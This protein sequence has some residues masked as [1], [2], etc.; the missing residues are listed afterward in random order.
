[1]AT[2]RAKTDPRILAAA[3]AGGVAAGAAVAEAAAAAAEQL[4]RRRER[5]LR[6]R[7]RY[8]LGAGEPLAA[9]VRRIA[10]G[11]LDLIAD[12][13]ASISNDAS[14]DPVHEARKA[15]KRLRA[16]VRLTRDQLGDD[17]RA[18]ENAAFRDAGRVL[19]SQRDAEVM[20]EALDDLTRRAGNGVQPDALAGLRATLVTARERE[21]EAD[22]GGSARARVLTAVAAARERVAEW[23]LP[24]DAGVDALAPG[25]RRI[26][27]QGRRAYRAA[28][29]EPTAETLHELRKRTKDLWHAVQ[30]A[31][32][33]APGR[34][35]KLAQ[36][37]HELSDALGADHDLVTLLAF[38]RERGGIPARER[39]LLE[40]LVAARQAELRKDA[41]RRARKLYALKPRR[42]AALARR[43]R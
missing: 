6:R 16:L 31:R 19:S 10:T 30:V 25:L 14:D 32:P 28:R 41:L 17:V 22:G 11:Q 9:G 33:A 21:A 5:R 20:V 24:E 13:L 3:G 2:R 26:Q 39:D 36:R 42:L 38:A 37:S 15:F 35:R 1:M 4:S 29:A 12:Q 34:M 27:R 18:R 23:P 43:S 7:R 8:R 40:R